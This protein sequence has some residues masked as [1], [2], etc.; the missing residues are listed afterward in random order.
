[1]GFSRSAVH[2]SGQTRIYTSKAASGAD[3]VRNF[4]PVCNSLVFG[5]RVGKDDAFMIYAGSLDDPSC[6][7]PT[8]AIFTRSRPTWTVIPPGLKIFE[9]GPS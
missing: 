4:C 6:F 9:G 3:A 1:M 7:R 8:I 5:G 2:F